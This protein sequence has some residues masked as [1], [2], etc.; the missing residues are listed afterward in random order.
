MHTVT[1]FQ[2]LFDSYVTRQQ[3]CDLVLKSIRKVSLFTCPQIIVF[4]L[5]SSQF[6]CVIVYGTFQNILKL[7]QQDTILSNEQSEAQRAK[8]K[9]RRIETTATLIYLQHPKKYDQE[10]KTPNLTFVMWKKSELRQEVKNILS[11]IIEH[12]GKNVEFVDNVDADK[13]KII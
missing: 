7:D 9:K 1:Q 10:M 8:V 3:M 5:F 11:R 4:I 13:W 12:D 6:Y 2:F